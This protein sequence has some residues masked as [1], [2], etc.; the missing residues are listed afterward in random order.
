MGTGSERRELLQSILRADDQED[1]EEDSTPDDEV[2]NQMIAR[3]EEEYEM[4]QKMD[5]ER[6]RQDAAL[7]AERK[8]RLIEECELP[9]FLLK[10]LDD[11]EEEEEERPVELGRGN[12]SRKETNYD[13]QLSEKEWLKAI[14]AED[15]DFEDDDGDD[16]DSPKKRGKK[17][18]RVDE[19]D[20]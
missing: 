9:E 3:S 8:P 11:E 10:D 7:G 19:E 15:E 20:V 13:D 18:H 6:R 12:R 4:F 16:G 17:K 2:V 14:G 1:E 5:I